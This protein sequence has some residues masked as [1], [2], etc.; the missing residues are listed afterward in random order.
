MNENSELSVAG[1]LL[2]VCTRTIE[3]EKNIG[4]FVT[5]NRKKKLKENEKGKN[6]NRGLR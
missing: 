5:I 3:R 4:R 1:Y 6:Q 2:S